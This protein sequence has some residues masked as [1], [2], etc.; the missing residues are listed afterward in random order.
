MEDSTKGA[1]EEQ[2]TKAPYQP[3]VNDDEVYENGYILIDKDRKA[4]LEIYGIDKTKIRK[5]TE[6]RQPISAEAFWPEDLCVACADC[7]SIL[8]PR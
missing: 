4:T 6:H 8:Q 3:K 2:E 7:Y 5:Y 1:A